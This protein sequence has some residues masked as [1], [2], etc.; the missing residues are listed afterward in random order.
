MKCPHCNQQINIGKILGSLKSK[1]KA[2]SSKMNG[3]KG[4]RPKATTLSNIKNNVSDAQTNSHVEA[5]SKSIAAMNAMP[6]Q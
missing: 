2:E 6:K 4:G 5:H 3:M 1:K